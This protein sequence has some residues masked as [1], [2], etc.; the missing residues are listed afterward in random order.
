MLSTKPYLWLFI[1][2]NE[3]LSRL[4]ILCEHNG[5]LD[6]VELGLNDDLA[7]LT[8]RSHAGKLHLEIF[9]TSI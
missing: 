7:K 5:R 8:E 3:V 2:F 4:R 6:G 9:L 1:P